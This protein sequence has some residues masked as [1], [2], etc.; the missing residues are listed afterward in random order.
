MKIV[1]RNVRSSSLLINRAYS[2]SD[3]VNTLVLL[4]FEKGKGYMKSTNRVHLSFDIEVSDYDESICTRLLTD[5]SKFLSICNMYDE[6]E[7]VLKDEKVV[8]K[9]GANIFQ[10]SSFEDVKIIPTE[11]F[12]K[13]YE[14]V[15]DIVITDELVKS[16]KKASSYLNKDDNSNHVYRHVFIEEGKLLAIDESFNIMISALEGYENCAIYRDVLDYLT[17]LNTLQ[18]QAGK[19]EEPINLELKISTTNYVLDNNLGTK[20]I[21]PHIRDIECPQIMTEEFSDFYTHETFFKV[22][23]KDMLDF[24]TSVKPFTSDLSNNSLYMS[25]KG[26]ILTLSTNGKDKISVN[27][28]VLENNGVPEDFTFIFEG[29]HFPRNIR[30]LEGEEITIEVADGEK[31]NKGTMKE[32]ILCQIYSDK[33]KEK[34]IFKRLSDR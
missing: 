16:L 5:A 28:T 12:S 17:I 1:T 13:D 8:F 7:V 22:N 18:P 14:T 27:F 21:L 3:T 24:L 26:D 34:I 11:L 31:L 32:A 9:N 30:N 6:L 2:N 33:D 10:L 23:K 4:D 19:D 20:I 15:N 25:L 29:T